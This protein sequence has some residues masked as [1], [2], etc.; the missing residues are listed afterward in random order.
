[1]LYKYNIENVSIYFLAGMCYWKDKN[2][3]EIIQ[4]STEVQNILCRNC[5]WLIKDNGRQKLC[6]NYNSNVRKSE[7]T[8]G[9]KVFCKKVFCKER[10]HLCRSLFFP[11]NF[12]KFLRTSFLQNISGQATASRKYLAYLAQFNFQNADIMKAA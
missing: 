6:R 9:K 8:T 5:I 11:V 10:K 12:A 4:K 2:Q 1:M 7:A 3:S